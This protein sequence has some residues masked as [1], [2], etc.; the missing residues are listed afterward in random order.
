M[1]REQRMK[2]EGWRKRERE[3][4]KER[5]RDRQIGTDTGIE[6]DSRYSVWTATVRSVGYAKSSLPRSQC[7]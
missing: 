3:E 1:E 4:R 5:R 6:R 7:C 2:K